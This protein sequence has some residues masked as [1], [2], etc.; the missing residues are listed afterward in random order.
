MPYMDG[1]GL[2]KMCFFRFVFKTC[3]SRF[4]WPKHSHWSSPFNSV[5]NGVFFKEVGAVLHLKHQTTKWETQ[6]P[7]VSREETPKNHPIFVFSMLNSAT[8]W[9]NTIVNKECEMRPHISKMVISPPVNQFLSAI[10]RGN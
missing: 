6:S 8:R 9:A 4:V 5:G 1:M 2:G 10:Y 3:F 7:Q